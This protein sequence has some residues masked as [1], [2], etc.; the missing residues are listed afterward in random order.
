MID[1]RTELNLPKSIISDN[2]ITRTLENSISL[3]NSNATTLFELLTCYQI[4]RRYGDTLAAKY[5][6]S[7]I[8]GK[9][10]LSQD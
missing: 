7:V 2:E 6:R 1:I 5:Y 4:S 3:V 9:L 10:N 8:L